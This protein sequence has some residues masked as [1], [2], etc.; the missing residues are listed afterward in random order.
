MRCFILILA[1][2][3]LFYFPVSAQKKNANFLLTDATELKETTK[4]DEFGDISEKEFAPKLKKY[5]EVLK[6]NKKL[7]GVV[8]FYNSFNH[9]LFRQ[10]EHFEQ[11]KIRSYFEYLTCRSYESPRITII[12]GGFFD[13][14]LTELWLVP[15]DAKLP[16]PKNSDYKPPQNLKYQ[17]ELLKTEG[18]DFSEAK[19]KKG[20]DSEENEEVSEKD[21]YF[22]E[23]LSDVLSKDESWHGVL[24]FYADDTEFDI[25]IIREKIIKFLKEQKT[26]LNRLKIIYGGYRK[27][28]EIESWLVPNNGFEPEAM[29][30]EKIEVEN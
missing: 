20:E 28:S 6:Q 4:F 8:I 13:K 3:V 2:L 29:P 26:D 30:Q 1:G 17:L 25:N 14:M 10:T 21:Y 11:I 7:R 9:N 27:N 16:E 5:F 12:K 24:I 19:L 15:T 23:I 22:D 18:F